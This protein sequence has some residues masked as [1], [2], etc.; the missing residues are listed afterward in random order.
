MKMEN[1]KLFGF[2]FFIRMN[3]RKNTK[4]LARNTHILLKKI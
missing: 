3:S 2:D 1:N 4:N